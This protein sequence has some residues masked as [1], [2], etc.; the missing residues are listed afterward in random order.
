[1]DPTLR[2]VRFPVG[3]LYY[4]YNPFYLARELENYFFHQ[5]FREF[6]IFVAHTPQGNWFW[7]FHVIF[8]YFFKLFSTISTA[9]IRYPNLYLEITE[10]I[11]NI[12]FLLGF[13]FRCPVFRS[14]SP[15]FNG[16]FRESDELILVRSSGLMVTGLVNA[17][18]GLYEIRI[19]DGSG[20]LFNIT[21]NSAC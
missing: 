4:L 13:V 1:M 11:E 2:S 20:Y 16:I 18:D 10:V 14:F 7:C 17:Y 6:E 8:L 15:I 12:R 5:N 9:E 19:H 21:K 3:L